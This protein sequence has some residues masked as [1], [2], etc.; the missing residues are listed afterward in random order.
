MNILLLIF[1]SNNWPI[2]LPINVAGNIIKKV[3]IY[4]KKENPINVNPIIFI[5]LPINPK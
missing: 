4:S 1:K 3:S 5:K 2:L